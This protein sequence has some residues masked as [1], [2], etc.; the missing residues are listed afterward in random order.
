VGTLLLNC[1][2]SGNPA[3]VALAGPSGRV[4]TDMA[5]PTNTMSYS[6]SFPGSMS[7]PKSGPGSTPT[8]TVSVQVGSDLQSAPAGNYTDSFTVVVSP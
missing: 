7:F 6:I 4:L 3:V 8:V 2:G 5:T 1:V